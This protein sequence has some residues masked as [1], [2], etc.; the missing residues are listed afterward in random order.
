VDVH[1]NKQGSGRPRN[2]RND[3]TIGLKLCAGEIIGLHI[4]NT[5]CNANCNKNSSDFDSLEMFVKF[6]FLQRNDATNF[7]D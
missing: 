1:T 2:V 7:A 4:S 5:E 6:H 3:G